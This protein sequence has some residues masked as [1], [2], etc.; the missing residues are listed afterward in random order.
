VSGEQEPKT[1]KINGPLKKSI[2]SSVFFERPIYIIMSSST[3]V[4]LTLLFNLIIIQ[5]SSL[6]ITNINGNHQA[7]RDGWKGKVIYQ[8]LTDRFDKTNS[9]LSPCDDL[10][11]YCGGTCLCVCSFLSLIKL[12]LKYYYLKCRYVRGCEEANGLCRES[13][14]GRD[15]DVSIY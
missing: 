11:K 5:S 13:W 4:R 14:C 7:N 8:F 10:S 2:S 1:N 15:L 12:T 6:S 9:D 3:I